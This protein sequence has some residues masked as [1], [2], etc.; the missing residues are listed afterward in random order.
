MR[1]TRNMRAG[2]PPFED[3]G[4]PLGLSKR[5]P[6]AGKNAASVL[7][8][9]MLKRAAAAAK[10]TASAAK[11]AASAVQ[12]AA[13]KAEAAVKKAAAEA[14]ADAAAAQQKTKDEEAA[15][16]KAAARSAYWQRRK[17]RKKET[18][19][20]ASEES[21]AETR[22][23]WIADDAGNRKKAAE[24]EAKRRRRSRGID[25]RLSDARLADLDEVCKR[26]RKLLQSLV[27]QRGKRGRGR[28]RRRDRSPA[29]AS[30]AG[31]RKDSGKASEGP[32]AGAESEPLHGQPP[33]HVAD[34][35]MVQ[36]PGEAHGSFL[37]A[38]GEVFASLAVSVMCAHLRATMRR[39]L[40]RAQAWVR[41]RELVRKDGNR[42]FDFLGFG[43]W[44]HALV[45]RRRRLAGDDESGILVRLQHPEKMGSEWGVD[46][47]V[48]RSETVASCK[49]YA[50]ALLARCWTS[51]SVRKEAI[52][53][54]KLM[55]MSGGQDVALD[56]SRTLAQSGILAGA[57][58]KLKSTGLLGGMPTGHPEPDASCAT[59]PDVPADAGEHGDDAVDAEGGAGKPAGDECG[60]LVGDC[61]SLTTGTPAGETSP[62]GA[63]V[64]LD[65]PSTPPVSF[66]SP[67][68]RLCRCRVRGSALKL[69]VPASIPRYCCSRSR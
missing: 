5:A 17:Q 40:R 51:A 15:A 22:P 61:A 6:A 7:K 36:A 8:K 63:S 65:A 62:L 56:H 53:G 68:C 44:F 64:V 42:R 28:W 66:P 60:E 9:A 1:Q 10:K 4:E 49:A 13:Q 3:A 58:L 52:K 43:L 27:A 16:K 54:H 45:Y 57:T 32:S 59:A 14:A 26:L 69:P 46:I 67:C 37:T 21:A 29:A 33:G 48:F 25:V 50:L 38:P 12:A 47:I 23:C 34:A 55:V 39:H 35:L 11:K 19:S 24:A 20:R 30:S 41:L 31:P 2:D 18:R